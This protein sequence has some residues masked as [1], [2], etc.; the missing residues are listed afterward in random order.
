MGGAD[1]WRTLEV[2]TNPPFT[3]ATVPTFGV[4]VRTDAA[5]D[6]EKEFHERNVKGVSPT[7]KGTSCR[8]H[9]RGKP[10]KPSSVLEVSGTGGG[11]R[12]HRGRSTEPLLDLGNPAVPRERHTAPRRVR[13][14]GRHSTHVPRGQESSRAASTGPSP[15]TPARRRP[16]GT[17]SAGVRRTRVSATAEGSR[18]RGGVRPHPCSGGAPWTPLSCHPLG[19]CLLEV[20]DPA[21]K[22]RREPHLITINDDKRVKYVKDK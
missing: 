6:G 18:A 14:R 8:V 16:R 9:T 7:R 19:V 5:V 17:W 15:D 22:R 21:R 11:T 12:S 2:G 1:V 10:P 3:L 20:D 4:G 13:R